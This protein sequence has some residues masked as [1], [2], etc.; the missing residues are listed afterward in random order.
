MQDERA[1]R[2]PADND[3]GLQRVRPKENTS[4]L[5]NP[6]KGCATFQQFNGEPLSAWRGESEEKFDFD[7]YYLPSSVAYFRWYWRQFQPEPDRFD[8]TMVEAALAGAHRCGQTLQV[9]LM[10]HGHNEQTAL[11]QWY[12]E[13]YPTV[14]G[15]YKPYPYTAAVY[16]GPEFQEQWGNVIWEFGRRFDGHPDLES[17]DMSFI[18]PWGE[19]AGDCSQEAIDRMIDIYRQAHPKTPLV[20]M[21]KH[22]RVDGR[23]GEGWRVDGLGELGLYKGPDIPGYV[24]W[25]HMYDWYPRIVQQRGASEVWKVGPVVFETIKVPSCWYKAGWDLDFVIQ[26]ALKY[27]GSV[28]MPKSAPL[29]K[30][31]REKLLKFCNDLG[32]RFVLR[33]ICCRRSLPRKGTFTFSCW[34]ENVGVAPIYHPYHFALRLS[35]H[36]RHYVYRSPSNVL[37]WLPGDAWLEE[38]FPLPDWIGTG[39]VEIS[40]AL[41]HPETGQARVRFANEGLAEDGWLPLASVEIVEE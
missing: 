22:K 41:V 24:T 2:W 38:K 32:Y 4:F 6:H 40:A 11:P 25:N 1:P 16:D 18:G 13:R 12:Q 8:W 21:L 10:P 37:E 26:Q 33:Q 34:I 36:G 20:A 14:P 19:G 9:R 3:P 7:E 15:T 27:H 29:P 35:Q 5:L 31:W 30:P 28:F 39:R 17:V 23:A